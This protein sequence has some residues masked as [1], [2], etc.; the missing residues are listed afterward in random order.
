MSGNTTSSPRR[1][2]A[3]T[4]GY[5]RRQYYW[6]IGWAVSVGFVNGNAQADAHLVCRDAVDRNRAMQVSKSRRSAPAPF[7]KSHTGIAAQS[8]MSE[9]QEVFRTGI[10]QQASL[11][12]RGDLA[13]RRKQSAGAGR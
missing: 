9:I 8:D 1:P 13:H 5:R 7:N 3:K 6:F 10:A 12:Q 4:I 2:Q 11:G